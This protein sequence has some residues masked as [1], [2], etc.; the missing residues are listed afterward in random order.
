MTNSFNCFS[1]G[2]WKDEVASNVAECE[3]KCSGEHDETCSIHGLSFKNKCV[4]ECA[5]PGKGPA[6][7]IWMEQL[8]P[9]DA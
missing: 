6:L 8:M 9:C 1:I 7:D 5:F 2:S 3:S 4:A